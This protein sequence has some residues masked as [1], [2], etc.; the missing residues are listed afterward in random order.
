MQRVLT[1]VALSLGLAAAVSGF[2]ATS[3]TMQQETSQVN[4]YQ[5][6]DVKAHVLE[7]INP[8]QRLVPIFHKGNWIKVG[9]PQN[10]EVGW[11]NRQE[12]QKAMSAYYEPNIQ[13]LYIH[14]TPGQNGQSTINVVAYKNGKKLSD[15]EAQVLYKRIEIQQKKQAE[16]MQRV[17]WNMD[18]VLES[19]MH[20][21][22][23]YF[24]APPNMGFAPEFIQPVIVVT[25]PSATSAPPLSEKQKNA[26]K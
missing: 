12:Y 20:H 1:T 15:K 2:A 16:Y 19:E 4:I 7:K 17:F 26:S 23:Q 9:D 10:G 11:I 24:V 5:N 14:T 6:P 22:P 21:M 8:A 25:Q 18:N 13:T 3:N